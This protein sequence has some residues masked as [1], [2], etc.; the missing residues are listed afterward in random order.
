M[1]DNLVFSLNATIPLFLVM[2]VG[3][4][5]SRL[6]IVNDNFIKNA[7]DFNFKVTL[8]ALLYVD[9]ASTDFRTVFDLEFLL[10]CIIVTLICILGLWG[11]TKVFMKD[12]DSVGEFVQASYR[13]SLA[14]NGMALVQSIYGSTE[15]AGMMILGAVPLYNIF[16]V[17][18]LQA[19]SPAREKS[20][21]AHKL[22]KTL[23]GIA[24]NPIIIAIVA[25]FLT[26]LVQIDWPEMIDTTL[27]YV[28]RIGTPLALICIGAAFDFREAFGKIGRSAF[29]AAIKLIIQPLIFVPIA[30][31]LGF[32]DE[33][34]VSILIMLAGPTTP[35]AFIMAKQYGYK[36]TI[37]SSAVALTTLFSSVT[38]TGFI[39]A[40]RSLGYI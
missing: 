6:K 23:L 7:N 21:D 12:K 3:Y 34:L 2:A 16:A 32:R 10:Y 1:L 5:V 27:S 9:M 37:T 4:L 40:L 11:L 26:A 35:V 38:L 18:I 8:P 33:K 13:C 25:G 30:V 29:A 14:V 20:K 28:G 24:K 15:M 19:E 31:L 22:K 17:I 39:F 36:G